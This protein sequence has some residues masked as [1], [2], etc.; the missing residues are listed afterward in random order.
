MEYHLMKKYLSRA[1]DV[2]DS[3][4]E[5]AV[6]A[7]LTLP[8]YCPDIERILS[9]TLIP[10][11]YIANVSGDRLNIEGGSCV[12]ILYTDGE[13]S[14]VRAYEHTVPFSES[15]PLKENA[16][17]CAVYVDTR[18]EYLNC[19]ALS[20]RKLSLHGAFSLYAKVAVK[21]G[22][23][24]CAYEDGD[25][26]EVK[27]E[28]M[29]VTSLAGLCSESFTVQEDIPTNADVGAVLAHRVSARITELRSIHNKIM[30]SA[31]LRLDLL[32]QDSEKRELSC[33]SYSVPVSRVIDCE[34]ADENTVIDGN[35]CV[36]S[37]EVRLSD[38][39]LDGSSLLGVEA[40]LLFSAMC[41]RDEEIEV[42][43]DAFST[44]REVELKTSPFSCTAGTVCRS[45]TDIAKAAVSVDEGVGKVIDVH[46]EKLVVS[47]SA[48][49]SGVLLNAKL[50]VSIL[51]ENADGEIRC[52][53]R[54]ASLPY[55]PD[56]GDCDTVERLSASL[57]SLSYRLTDDKT[58]ELRA[59][60][61]YR[62]TLCR[63][64]G[65]TAVTAVSADDDA[66]ARQGDSALVLYYTAED[67]TVWA[68]AKRYYSRPAD[69]IAENHL[70]GDAIDSGM[71]LLIPTA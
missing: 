18:P 21:S 31:E 33:M 48:T 36:L 6:D 67:D 62:M 50:C 63:R 49:D 68:I 2:L 46:G 44:E 51:Y 37:A 17:D 61:C 64:A 9:C 22:L 25:D 40:R 26:L 70:E 20:P 16:G 45:F 19:R 59:E 47:S 15:L 3:V 11:V 56:M 7:D 41:T 13:K 29:E 60:I 42:L 27:G 66:P 34:G 14:I 43:S 54:D 58:L 5:Q 12:R 8:D 32:C 57:E 69:I 24:Y 52:V 4:T 23:S 10:K 28:H 65:C 30:L 71:L 35:L 39:A 1:D 55:R 53:E 38:D